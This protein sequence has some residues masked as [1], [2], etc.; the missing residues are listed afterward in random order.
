[1]PSWAIALLCGLILNFLT[2]AY[3]AGLIVNRVETLQ[4]RFHYLEM[5]FNDFVERNSK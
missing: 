4:E 5:R 1:M 2:V 3:S